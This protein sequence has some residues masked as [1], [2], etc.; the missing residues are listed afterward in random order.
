MALR[1]F[2]LKRLTLQGLDGEP[3]Q[4]EPG[5][6]IP[7]GLVELWG[8]RGIHPAVATGRIAPLPAQLAPDAAEA[9]SVSPRRRTATAV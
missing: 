7:D 6:F 8:D 4:L 9:A 5:D 3:L 1:Y 2:A